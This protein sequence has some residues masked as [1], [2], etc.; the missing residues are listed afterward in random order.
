MRRPAPE[1]PRPVG[2]GRQTLALL[3][4]AIGAALLLLALPLDHGR[5]NL[6]DRDAF[7]DHATAVLSQPDVQRALEGEITD[8]IVARA[9]AALDGA[10]P[11]IRSLAAAVVENPRFR[12][13]WRALVRDAQTQVLDPD[14]QR[15]AISVRDFAALAD[16]TLGTLP[17]D[18]APLLDGVG[19]V[20]L[21]AWDRGSEGAR[22]AD[23]AHQLGRL[24]LA[25]LALA[26]VAFA[27]ALLVSRRR[28]RTG[29]AIGLAAAVA[30]AIVLVAERISRGAALD[31]AAPGV[32]RE[33]AGAAWDELVGGLRTTATV[34][35]VVGLLLAAVL[36]VAG[37]ARRTTAPAVPWT[38]L[39]QPRSA[40]PGHAADE[41]P[42]RVLPPRERPREQVSPRAPAGGPRRPRPPR[43]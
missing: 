14:R 19:T 43:S 39:D 13:T 31:R 16:R 28:T 41:H 26:L 15:V 7:A 21:V 6:L 25:L 9:P 24:G 11:R 32:E 40:A 17:A 42:T 38:G 1:D 34:V 8:A 10:R 30:A 12:R 23:R 27:T 20:E 29:A 36:A 4:V 37:R 2:T 5:R 33:V 22:L 3:L 18:V 35:L